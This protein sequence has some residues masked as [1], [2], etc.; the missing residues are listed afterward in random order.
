MTAYQVVEPAE[1]TILAKALDDHCA[2]H[3]I[4]DEMDREQVA[5]KLFGL[6]RQGV[7]DL[8]SLSEELERV[9]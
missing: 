6:F 7:I 9:G 8:A 4:A 1:L 2:R 5:L 3:R